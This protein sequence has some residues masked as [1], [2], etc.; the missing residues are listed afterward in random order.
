MAKILK[1]QNVSIIMSTTVCDIHLFLI[2]FINSMVDSFKFNDS[3][4]QHLLQTH[5]EYNEPLLLL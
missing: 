2:K 4:S 5:C 1:F 3:H